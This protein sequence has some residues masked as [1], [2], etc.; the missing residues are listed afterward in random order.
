MGPVN[1]VVAEAVYEH[2]HL[3]YNRHLDQVILCAVYGVCKVNKITMPFKNIINQ[4]KKLKEP[5]VHQTV[6]RRDKPRIR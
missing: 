6:V 1:D 4:Y 5:S 2:T 3:L